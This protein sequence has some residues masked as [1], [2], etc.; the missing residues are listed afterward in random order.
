[1]NAPDPVQP[2]DDYE[3]QDRY[4]REEGRVFL[5]GTQALVRLPLDQAQHLCAVVCLC[6]HVDIAGLFQELPDT[7][8]HDGMIIG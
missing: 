8:A 4:L 5:T 2:L 7:L 1:M 3:L 6:D